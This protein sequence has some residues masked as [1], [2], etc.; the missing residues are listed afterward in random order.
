MN[1]I[2]AEMSAMASGRLTISLCM[3]NSRYLNTHLSTL[4]TLCPFSSGLPLGTGSPVGLAV[5]VGSTPV[6]VGAPIAMLVAD[7]MIGKGALL[8]EPDCDGS[9][10]RPVAVGLGSAGADE[11]GLTTALGIALGKTDGRAPV[12][13]A[14]EPVGKMPEGMPEGKT[15][16]GML[17]G[18]GTLPVT[19]HADDG[20]TPVG[21]AELSGK[22]P[23]GRLEEGKMPL[24]IAEPVG[25]TPEGNAEGVTPPETTGLAVAVMKALSIGARREEIS[26]AMLL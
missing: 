18:V 5:P 21:T 7:G 23:L 11:T 10:G 3:F 8:G 15:P 17:E 24:G 20:K 9:C 1:L 13:T 14:A 6:E 4:G 2:T 26:A 19:I 16:A 25:K 12:G 22:I